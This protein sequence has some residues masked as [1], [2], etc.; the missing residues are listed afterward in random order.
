MGPERQPGALICSIFAI[1]LAVLGS[2]CSEELGPE[3]MPITHVSGVV[4]EGGSPVGGGWIEFIPVEGTVGNFRSARLRP[5]GSFEANKVA[6][7]ENALRLVNAPI[8]TPG[9][10]RLFGAFTTPIRRM[11]PER[12]RKPL[13][14]DLVEELILYQKSH[15]QASDRALRET[16]TAP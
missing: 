13:K 8:K 7:G 16:G 14:I 2:G 10:A 4:L 9:W 5:D 11:I 3:R 1:M 6:V 12:P 15:S